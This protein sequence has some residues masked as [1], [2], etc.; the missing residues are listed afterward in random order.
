MQIILQNFIKAKELIK[1]QQ[2]GHEVMP[3][4]MVWEEKKARPRGKDE[5]IINYHN[6]SDPSSCSFCSSRSF[7]RVSLSQHPPGIG[8]CRCCCEFSHGKWD[9]VEE[10]RLMEPQCRVTR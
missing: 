2:K 6:I 1:A 7:F 10:A 5:Y 9:F 8:C 4:S 3:R